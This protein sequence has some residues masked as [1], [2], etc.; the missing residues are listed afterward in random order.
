[1]TAAAWGPRLGERFLGSGHGAK[2]TA[3]FLAPKPE[4]FKIASK[5]TIFG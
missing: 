2:K 5:L 4:K 3:N 1:V